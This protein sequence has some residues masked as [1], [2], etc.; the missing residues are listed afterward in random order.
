MDAEDGN[1]MGNGNNTVEDQDQDQ[2]D[3]QG[4]NRGFQENTVAKMVTQRNATHYSMDHKYRGKVIIFNHEH[5]R[6]AGLKSRSGTQ[7]DCNN[8]Y[9]TM[10]GLGFD[11]TVCQDLDYQEINATVIEAVN[12]DYSDCDCFVMIVLSHG[13]MGILYSRNAP[14]KPD[15]L[16]SP[17]TADR[18]PTL[19]GKPK[20]FFIQACQGDKLDGGVTM[21]T[22]TDGH[23]DESYRIPSQ[24]DFLICYSTVPGYYSWRN[25]TKGSWFMQALCEQLQEYAYKYDILT[26]LTF[27]NQR[28]ALD[29][30]SNTPDTPHMHKQ[31][32]IP[33]I[34]SMLTR[35]LLF[36]NKG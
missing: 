27:V 1:C 22:E 35:L 20:L 28:V 30:E 24:A 21:R 6:V 36:T 18:C 34:T 14:Y 8:I 11:V 33:C 12:E 9:L 10:K 2:H 13:E 32:Q 5:F 17:F 23:P 15:V 31:K 7:N 29:F 3:A 25:T 4:N 16:W 26:L 19:A